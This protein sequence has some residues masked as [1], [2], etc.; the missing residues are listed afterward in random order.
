MATTLRR[1]AIRVTLL[2]APLSTAAA[3]YNFGPDVLAIDFHGQF[4]PA[5]RRVLDGLSPYDIRWMDIERDVAFPYNAVAALLFVPFALVPLWLA[6]IVFVAACIASVP[7]ALRLLGIRDWRIYAITLIWV[8][9]LTG[10]M[11]ANISL[12]LVFGVALMWHQRHRPLVTGL[13]LAL[14][15]SVKLFV[16]PLA[17]WLLACRHYS[18]LAYAS[19][20]G[21][22]LN[23]AAWA[24]IGF[25]QIGAYVNV[26]GLVTDRELPRSFSVLRVALDYGASR[27]AAYALALALAAIAGAATFV[28]ARRGRA[29]SALLLAT[30]TSL[31]A[32][33]VAWDHYVALLIVPLALLRPRFDLVWMVPVAI[34]PVA[35]ALMLIGETAS[36]AGQIALVAAMVAAALRTPPAE[37]SESRRDLLQGQD[38]TGPRHPPV[39]GSRAEPRVS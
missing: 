30:V 26:L 38:L 20:F 3:L 34:L 25:D 33:P 22:V 36:L 9:V 11:Y 5:G 39:V 12:P 2:C 18:A 15:V 19:L 6:K 37:S 13:L 23:V 21:L 1:V 31:L 16:W 28:V 7:L 24:V 32:T 17:L 14:L 8:P 4:W 27:P 29:R 35:M 10:A